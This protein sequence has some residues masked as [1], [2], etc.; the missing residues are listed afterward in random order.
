MNTVGT[1][2]QLLALSGNPVVSLCVKADADTRRALIGVRADLTGP[3]IGV[4]H[5][6]VCAGCVH[7]AVAIAGTALVVLRA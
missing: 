6:A 7:A 1:E 2:D 3:P 4:R 5:A